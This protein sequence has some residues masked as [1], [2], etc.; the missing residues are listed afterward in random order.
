MFAISDE[1][2]NVSPGDAEVLA[3]LIG[4]GVAFGGDPPGGSPPAFHLTPG[5][6]R[7][8]RRLATR[9]GSGGKMAG[10]AIIWAAGLE[11]TLE[12]R[13]HFGCSRRGRT[14]KGPAKG[15]KQRQRDNEQEHEQKHR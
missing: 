12:S 13:A 4:T 14:M 8:K 11:Q 9:R 5:T 7:R 2:V 1:G 3:L 15:T 6:H 10:R